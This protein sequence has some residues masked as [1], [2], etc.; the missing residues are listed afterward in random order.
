MANRNRKCCA[1]CSRLRGCPYISEGTQLSVA[2]CDS[3]KW[4]Y[5]PADEMLAPDGDRW[6][7][8]KV[9]QL[10]YLRHPEDL[11]I[12]Q[13]K[14]NHW[15]SGI[16]D[17]YA[18]TGDKFI[19]YEIKVTRADYLSDIR[20]GKW[21]KYLPYCNEM[22]FVCPHGMIKREEVPKG[23]GLIYISKNGDKTRIVKQSLREHNTMK[24]LVFDTLWY[25]A[26]CRVYA[27]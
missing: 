27:K 21:E 10:L 6:T 2:I 9:T 15:G 26:R 5:K 4:K 18:I 3:F 20:A 11:F 16:M 19:C 23:V 24:N 8:F 25:I 7:E 17:G 1:N 22:F 14:I 12:P 13:C